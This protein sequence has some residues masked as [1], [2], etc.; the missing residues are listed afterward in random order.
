MLGKQALATMLLALLAFSASATVIYKWVD[1]N[2]VLHY[3]QEPPQ[4][5]ALAETLHSKDIEPPKTGYIAPQVRADV[6][7]EPTD[8]EKSAVLI[9][10]KDAKQ[11]QSICKSAK[12]NLDILTTHTKLIRQTSDSGESV[13]MTEEDRQASIAQQQERIKLFCD[14]K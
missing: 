6:P 5:E 9:K 12:H 7:P 11:A 4:E 1:K 10:E 8:L 13:A 2:G 3:S 14:K